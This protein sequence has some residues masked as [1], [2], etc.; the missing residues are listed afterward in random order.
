MARMSTWKLQ[1]LWKRAI[2][3]PSVDGLTKLPDR[4]LADLGLDRRAVTDR[5]L[6][7]PVDVGNDRV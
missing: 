6:H 2:D 3:H 5:P 1:A 7:A 4:D